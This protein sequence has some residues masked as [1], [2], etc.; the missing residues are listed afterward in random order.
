MR[1][2]ASEADSGSASDIFELNVVNTNDA[3]TVTGSVAQT[4]RGTPLAFSRASLLAQASDIDPTGDVLS[5]SAVGAAN[6]GS[7]VLRQDGSVL[8][9]PEAGFVGS[10]SFSYTVS[11][12]KGGAATATVAVEVL[13]VQLAPVALDTALRMEEDGALVLDAAS[14]HYSDEDGGQLASV[15]LGAPDAGRLLFDGSLVTGSITVS[16]ADLDAGKLVFAPLADA[17][18]AGYARL[19]FRVENGLASN[20]ATLTVDVAPV[21]DAPLAAADAASAF[22]GDSAPLTGNVLANDR[23]PDAGTVLAVRDPGTFAGAWGTLSLQS[24]G[25]YV[26]VIDSAKARSIAEG[27]VVADT[28]RYVASDGSLEQASEL[29]VS[30]TGRNDAPVAGAD[31]AAV[32]E[33]GAVTAS[34]N[35]LANDRDPDAGSTLRVAAPGSLRGLYGSLDLAA[36]GS[37]C[38]SLDNESAAVQALAAG[39]TML[40]RFDYE[41]SDGVAA[42]PAS[43]LITIAGAN[44]A[45]VTNQDAAG[46]REDGPLAASGNVLA[47]DTDRDA[48]TVLAVADAGLRSGRHGTLTLLASGAWTYVLDNASAAVQSLRGGQV[49]EEV[50]AYAASDGSAATPG[51]LT[52]RISGSNDGPDA[53]DDSAAIAEDGLAGVTGNVLANDS[54]ADS[55]TLLRVTTAGTLS[56]SYGSL[57]LAADGSYTYVLNQAAVQA[58]GAGQTAYERFSY[59]IVDDDLASPL[60]DTAFLGIAIAGANDGP[61]LARALADQK[62]A[63]GT[64]FTYQFDAASFNDIDQGDVLSYSATLSDGKPLPAWLRFD[65]ATRTFDGTVA[66]AQADLVLG[67]RVTATD[68][69]GASVHDDFTLDIAGTPGGKRIEG[70][71][72]RDYLVGTDYND[73]IDGKESHDIMVGGKG[74]DIYYVDAQCYYWPGDWCDSDYRDDDRGYRSRTMINWYPGWNFDCEADDVIEKAGEGFDT[75]YSSASYTL[76]ANVEALRLLGYADL[77]GAG[78]GLNNAIFGNAGRNTLG[79][80]AGTDLLF[81]G[82]GADTLSDSLGNNLLDGGAGNDSLSGGAGNEFLAGGAGDDLITTGKGADVIAFNR[83]D[84][85][86]TVVASSGKDNTLSL[87]HGITYADLKF[88]K[89][90]KDLVLITGSNEQLTFKDWYAGNWLWGVDNRSVATLQLFTEGGSDYS[91]NSTNKLNNRKIQ[92]FD[93]ASLVAKFDAARSAN[94]RLTNWS[95]AS[96]LPAAYLGGSDTSAI[97][98]E[99]AYQYARSGDLQAVPIPAAQIALAAAEFGVA[100]QALSAPAPLTAWGVTSSVLSFHVGAGE[101]AVLGGETAV[102]AGSGGSQFMMAMLSGQAAPEQGAA[103]WRGAPRKHGLADL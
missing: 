26:Y 101:A 13:Q 40:E 10:A 92:Q 43:L 58:L 28:F 98:G 64:R 99:L 68:L 94:P 42:T 37:Y 29:V 27:A 78:N 8:F 85:R 49:V 44:D 97:G 19:S 52:V 15:T 87:G 74:D 17:N 20:A 21:N 36:D 7:V 12:G 24:D 31:A 14:F 48:G 76:A 96:S 69:S 1:V 82:A 3:P 54:D 81:G 51:T 61:A 77:E 38:Y 57:A 83:G 62:A 53:A 2:T 46:V 25:G 59:A 71:W 72:W 84:G 67:L 56:G 95:L 89:N 22:D 79:G 32:A 90:D 35:V 75:V 88:V 55:G 39:Q 4:L 73:T 63:S 33:D 70:T 100:K 16:R 47:N 50:F 23:D 11:D 6:R 86:D 65:A 103:F 93:F 91:V 5:V 60:T 18:G 66:P 45:P 102:Q 80:G 41:A 9:T 34:G 30:I